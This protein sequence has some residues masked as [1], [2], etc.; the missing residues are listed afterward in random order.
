VSADRGVIDDGTTTRAKHGR[1]FV[2]HRQQHAADVDV[3]DL[4]TVLDRL[5]GGE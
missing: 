1:D 5:L 2:L 3:T 4:M